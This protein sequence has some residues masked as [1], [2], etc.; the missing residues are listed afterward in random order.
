MLHT[1]EL[2]QIPATTIP[3]VRGASAQFPAM[4]K[5]VTIKHTQKQVRT[6]GY[7]KKILSL[8]LKLKLFG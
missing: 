3:E 8:V 5:A 7:E 2:F 6:E 4:S 1:W